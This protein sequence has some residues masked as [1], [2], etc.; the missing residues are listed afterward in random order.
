MR[1]I[2]TAPQLARRLALGL[3]LLAAPL[4]LAAQ[5]VVENE[6]AKIFA[7]HW[8]QSKEA[9]KNGLLMYLSE[10]RAMQGD[11][12]SIRCEGDDRSIRLGFGDKLEGDRVVFR[13]DDRAMT[14]A[15]E[16]TGVTADP[17]ISRGD[18]HGYRM[19]FAGTD[20]LEAFLG[21]LR[22]GT[23][24]VIEGQELPISLSGSSQALQEQAAYCQ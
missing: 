22:R 6:V 15:V 23:E 11:Y 20:Q 8:M 21:D 3:A 13:V 12:F 2:C 5:D 24:L 10:E 17:A 7:E 16:E 1:P 9:D 14:F 4:P 19:V 18:I